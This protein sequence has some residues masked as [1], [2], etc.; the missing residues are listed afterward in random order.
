MNID[1]ELENVVIG[2]ILTVK[3]VMEL[4]AG[5]LTA[6][7]FAS[8]AARTAY[9]AS[10]KAYAE[11][12]VAEPSVVLEKCGAD[13]D[14]FKKYLLDCARS[15][16]S[17]SSFE[18]HIRLLKG[19]ANLKK[20][21][22][23]CTELSFDESGDEDVFREKLGSAL[24]LLEEISPV[25]AVNTAELYAA[26]VKRMQQKT[27]FL[28]TGF[29]KLD[30]H[31]PISRGDYIIIA[32]RPSSGKTAFALRAA[33]ELAKGH[34]TVFYSFETSAVK[35]YER[36]LACGAGVELR[37]IKRKQ[38]GAREWERIN[39]FAIKC[40]NSSLIFVE[41][42]GMTAADIRASAIR[43]SAEVILIDYISLI[44]SNAELM[45][46]RMTDIS[47]E[48]HTM[49]QSLKVAVIALSQL[50]RSSV[51]RT[52]PLMSD[53]R[54]SGQLEQDADGIVILDTPSAEKEEPERTVNVHI[55]KNKEGAVGQFELIFDAK[56]QRFEQV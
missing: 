25:S 32:G 22:D 45:R 41:A 53:L 12:S 4:C 16:V 42:A 39:S 5:R 34:T 9:E 55:V 20:A 7:D 27:D 1:A 49:A 6:D 37:L 50:N 2:E 38:L 56:R 19:R 8:P 11:Y 23:I 52:K 47:I 15:V 18:A 46:D 17:D 36:L 54:E 29:E 31:M 3:G 40:S 10:L 24:K 14:F 48:L 35:L 33:Y 13:R 43:L 44:K 30:K 51:E 21:K 26:F 28:L